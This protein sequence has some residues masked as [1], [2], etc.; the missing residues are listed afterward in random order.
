MGY[1]TS[2]TGSQ[3]LLRANQIL[4]DGN[5][6]QAKRSVNQWFNTNAYAI[7]ATYTFGDAG[8]NTLIGPD[9]N[10]WDLSLRK[11][12]AVRQSQNLEFRAEFFNVLNHPN[13]A[14]PDNFL[15]DGPGAFGV[16]T[17]TGAD[18]RQIQFALK[19]SF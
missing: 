4:P 14:Q 8:R 12:F 11:V 13:F 2:N 7:P 10:E 16:I 9:T 19:Y 18:N 1:D 15:T 5:L 3:G 6:P 17:S